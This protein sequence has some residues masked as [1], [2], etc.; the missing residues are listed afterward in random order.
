[1]NL[2]SIQ[3]VRLL[4]RPYALSDAADLVRLV[5]ARE[6]G[7]T[8]LRIPQPYREQDATDFIASSLADA[9]LGR[10]VRLAITIRPSGELCGGIGLGIEPERNCA[11]LGYWIGV[12]YWG[13]GYATETAAAIVAYGFETLGLHR[14]YAS[15]FAGNDACGSVL[16]K[17]GM[18]HEG[19]LRSHIRKWE[20]LYHLELYGML[21][22]EHCKT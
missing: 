12:P 4:L 17:I 14:I 8:T 5:G 22:R 11:E 19:C 18:Q 13:R 9:E 16:R 20:K 15:H 3:T 21:S 10:S 1:M 2:P 7:A 6:V